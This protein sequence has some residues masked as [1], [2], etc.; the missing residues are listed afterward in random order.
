MPK[1]EI[2]FE[3]KNL[4]YIKLNEVLLNDYLEMVNNPEIQR[5]IS[6][7]IKK[8]TYED[9]LTWLK[10]K[11]KEKAPIFTIIEKETNNFVGNIEIMH[12]VNNIGEI[13]ICLALTKQNKHYGQEA[14]KALINY[15][16]ENLNIKGYE[17]NVYNDNYCAIH[18]YEKV[19]FTIYGPG[20]KRDDIHMIYNK[21]E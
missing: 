4:Y 2:I 17:L 1:Y 13:G 9:E 21:K 16:Y 20:K 3:S 8:F 7:Q 10:M 11:I 19:G 15:G 5:G 18:C 12:I 14:I 6:H